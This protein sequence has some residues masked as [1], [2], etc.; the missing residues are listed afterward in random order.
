MERE[1]YA[2]TNLPT[3][4]TR[5]YTSLFEGSMTQAEADFVDEDYQR[6]AGILTEI[7]EYLDREELMADF[8]VG[9]KYLD[10]VMAAFAQN[11]TSPGRR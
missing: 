2:I 7:W 9:Q 11:R 3:G 5:R 10:D 8:L 6:V 4:K 1:L